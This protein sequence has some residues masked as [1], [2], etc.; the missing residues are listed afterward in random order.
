MRKFGQPQAKY[1]RSSVQRLEAEVE[2]A[3]HAV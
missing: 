1:M 3:T 2:R